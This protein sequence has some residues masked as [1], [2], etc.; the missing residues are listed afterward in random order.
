MHE[1]HQ[2]TTRRPLPATER[3]RDAAVIGQVLALLAGESRRIAAYLTGSA[4]P[5]VDVTALRTGP[6]GRDL[7]RLGAIARGEATGEPDRVEEAV[8][9][10]LQLLFWPAGARDYEVPD[11]F[12]RTDLGTIFL[13]AADHAGVGDAPAVAPRHQPGP[14]RWHPGPSPVHPTA[15]PTDP[16]HGA[17]SR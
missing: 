6:A 4:G 2:D 13:A 8:E 9:S 7:A 10:I 1:F 16:T 15:P 3:D 5:R 12:W 17:A 14:G 11:W